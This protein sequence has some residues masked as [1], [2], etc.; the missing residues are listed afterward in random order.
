MVLYWI[1]SDAR[2]YRQFVALR[3]GELLELT[4]VEEWRWVP[5]KDNV[6]DDATKWTVPPSA[7]SKSRWFVGPRFLTQPESEWPT[8]KPS[9]STKANNQI[10]TM[11][12][13][14]DAEPDNRFLGTIDITNSSFEPD[15]TKYSKWNTLQHVQAYVL[16]FVNNVRSKAKGVTP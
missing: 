9:A 11:T 4:S 15:V 7:D 16:R 2:K 8:Q 12:E 6:A 10:L 14:K 13:L 1:R 5:T 3:I